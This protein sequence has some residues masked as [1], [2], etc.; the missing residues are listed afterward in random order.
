MSLLIRVVLFVTI[1][2]LAG[3]GREAEFI[4]LS[5]PNMLPVYGNT[6]L[7][8]TLYVGSNSEFHYFQAS[9]GKSFE[10]YQIRIDDVKI[11]P[12]GFDFNSSRTAIVISVQE[13]RVLLIGASL[14]SDSTP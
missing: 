2:V 6:P 10:K 11:V 5:D 9:N 12:Q 4:V 8:H 3:C 1:L 13:N 14:N 7:N